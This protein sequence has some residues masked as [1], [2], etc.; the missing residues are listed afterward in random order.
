VFAVYRL[1]ESII[2]NSI[3]HYLR[4]NELINDSQHGFLRKRSTCT[5]LLDSIHDWAVALNYKHSVDVIYID[6]RKAFD[7]VSHPKLISKLESYG[8]SGFL[9][10]WLKAFL[11]NRSQSVKVDG[12]FSSS[13]S[14]TSGVPQGSVLGPT[15]F[16]LFINDITDQL[17]NLDVS[18]K[19]FADDLKLYSVL[20]VG[21]SL[22][23]QRA[24][25]LI[26]AWAADW[27]MQMSIEKC[28]CLRIT[29]K[30][31]HLP[32]MSDNYT[33]Q[34]TSLSWST[35]VRDL[36]VL[37]DDKLTFNNHVSYIV[38]KAHV[39]AGLILRSFSSRNISLLIKAYLTYVRP[40]LEYCSS[41][42]SPYTLTNINQLESV[43]RSFTRKLYGLLGFSYSERLLILDLESLQQR[44]LECDLITLY[45]LIHGQFTINSDKFFEFCCTT[46]TRGHNLK[47]YKPNTSVNA[48]KY[49]FPNRCI[50]AWNSLPIDTVNAQSVAQ[51][52][53]RLTCTNLR[54]FCIV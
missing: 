51:F 2:N 26:S 6:F 35:E 32:N 50:D 22:D 37:I 10:H 24:C 23:L 46:A 19:L 3:V 8:F 47:L 36:G 45:K 13:V 14:V 20:D 41:V 7:T 54:R 53:T 4:S 40:M 44:R 18:V 52:K 21:V 39:R 43:Q 34:T 5:N 17:N 42:W 49:C 29:N 48:Y 27:Q 16:L 28:L 30:K 15:L 25:D 38:H 9:L 31:H 11:S 12:H 1:M 33:L